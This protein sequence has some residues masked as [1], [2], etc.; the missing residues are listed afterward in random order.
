MSVGHSEVDPHI[1]WRV[2]FGDFAKDVVRNNLDD[3]QESLS[4][5]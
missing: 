1:I 4:L 2:E 3:N 5:C